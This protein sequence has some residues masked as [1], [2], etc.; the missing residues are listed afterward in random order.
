MRYTIL[1]HWN[2]KDFYKY[3]SI[4]FKFYIRLE[5]TLSLLV[6]MIEKKEREEE[7][8]KDLKIQLHAI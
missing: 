4:L 6:W 5:K 3:D 8:S 1:D 2:N 7:C